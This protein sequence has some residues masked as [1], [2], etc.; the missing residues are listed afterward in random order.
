[1]IS[2]DGSQVSQRHPHVLAKISNRPQLKI[3][4]IGAALSAQILYALGSANNNLS[5]VCIHLY[6]MAGALK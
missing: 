4:V 1:M 6:S 3:W 5:L 2:F